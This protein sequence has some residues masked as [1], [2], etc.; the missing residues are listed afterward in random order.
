M[1]VNDHSIDNNVVVLHMT[2]THFGSAVPVPIASV[3]QLD[4]ARIDHTSNIQ[5]S[6]E[7]TIHMGHFGV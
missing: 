2:I 7:A 4:V 3:E 6:T 1:A 5:L